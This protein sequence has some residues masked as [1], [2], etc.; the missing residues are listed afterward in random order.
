MSSAVPRPGP[1]ELQV[2][3]LLLDFEEAAE[4]LRAVRNG[5]VDAVVVAGPDG[6]QVL[7]FR[8]ATH[9]YRVLVEAM[10]EGAALLTA[11]GLVSYCNSRFAELTG[12]SSESPGAEL[13]AHFSAASRPRFDDLLKSALD[14]PVRGELDL[15]GER[16]G[17]R[18]VQLSL[19]PAYIDR[20]PVVCAVI[21]DLT[22]HHRQERLYSQMSEELQKR[23]RT[24]SVASHELRQPLSA[25]GFLVAALSQQL[26]DLES[27]AKEGLLRLTDRIGRQVGS[28]SALVGT[29]LDLAHLNTGRLEL[30]VGDVD[31]AVITAATIERFELD[32]RR[33]SS[34]VQL[35]AQSVHGRWDR[36]RLEQAIGN[37]LSNAIK[38]G[39]GGVIR[40]T[41]SADERLARIAV[42]DDGVGIPPEALERIFKPYERAQRRGEEGLG[43][44]LHVT[45]EIVA[46]HGGTIRVESEVGKGSR[47]T[48]ELPR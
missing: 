42:E 16:D 36:L 29:L 20:V 15:D 37:L 43:L 45:S 22:E 1:I 33:T 14:H 39:R 6:Q 2:H 4:T 12:A 26:R 35:E 41:I 25:L 21:T 19:S 30:T 8:E 17:R 9:S 47:F 11:S 27:P 18:P 40:V 44:G 48:I 31:L 3:D 10:N 13:R 7:T 38:Y 28:L 32:L 5:T 34:T 24:M 46:A 23:D